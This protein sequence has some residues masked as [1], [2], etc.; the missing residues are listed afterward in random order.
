MQKKATKNNSLYI[1]NSE[2]NFNNTS[3]RKDTQEEF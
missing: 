1:F 3:K 2:M